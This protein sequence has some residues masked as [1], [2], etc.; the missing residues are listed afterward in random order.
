M[1]SANA[2]DVVASAAVPAAVLVAMP[3]L[4][5]ADNL[6][7]PIGYQC[8]ACR[9]LYQT[10]ALFCDCGSIVLLPVTASDRV[11]NDLDSDGG[12]T[13]PFYCSYLP[14]QITVV[15]F[16]GVLKGVKARM[17]AAAEWREA[18]AREERDGRGVD[19]LELMKG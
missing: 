9:T 12:G 5:P 16:V 7:V 19:V 3:Q 15:S 1:N 11:Q 18:K 17:A 13:G 10:H 6:P 8:P 4:D 2:A 14:D